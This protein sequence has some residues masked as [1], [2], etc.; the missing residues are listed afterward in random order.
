MCWGRTFGDGL[1]GG[2]DSPLPASSFPIFVGVLSLLA[3]ESLGVVQ[4]TLGLPCFVTLYGL[5]LSALDSVVVHAGS[6]CEWPDLPPFDMEGAP[7][8]S[9]TGSDSYLKAE[10]VA[11]QRLI[12]S[13]TCPRGGYEEFGMAKP[14][15]LLRS[16]SFPRVAQVMEYSFLPLPNGIAGVA[17]DG[18]AISGAPASK[19]LWEQSQCGLVIKQA[20]AEYAL[21]PGGRWSDGPCEV[22]KSWA[23]DFGIFGALNSSHEPMLGFMMDGVPLF[24]PLSN[25]S[26]FSLDSCGG[27]TDDLPFYHYHAADSFDSYSGKLLGCLRAAASGGNGFAVPPPRISWP[28]MSPQHFFEL[29]N[30]M[31]RASLNYGLEEVL[32]TN[33]K[34]AARFLPQSLD[35]SSEAVYSI[36]RPA[37]VLNYSVCWGRGLTLDEH[38]VYLGSLIY[39]GPFQKDYLCIL[40]QECIL[41]IEGAGLSIQSS[42][43]I[44][45]DTCELPIFLSLNGLGQMPA[46]PVLGAGNFSLYNLGAIQMAVVGPSFTKICWSDFP[47]NIV[48]VGTLEFLGPARL[49]QNFTCSPGQTCNLRV[50]EYALSTSPSLLRA[51]TSC[52]QTIMEGRRISAVTLQVTRKE[53]SWTMDYSFGI[54]PADADPGHFMLCWY[55]ISPE[56]LAEGFPGSPISSGIPVGML[57]LRG[58]TELQV[59]PPAVAGMFFRLQLFGVVLL[60]TD[61]IR[62][63]DNSSACGSDSASNNSQYVSFGS[64]LA[65][66]VR[67]V[68]ID[69]E[70]PNSSTDT[71]DGLR[72]SEHDSSTESSTSSPNLVDP[73]DAAPE[74]STDFSDG[75]IEGSEDSDGGV[76]VRGRVAM[77]VGVW[78]NVTIQVGGV[79]K[80]CWCPGH[81]ACKEDAD[82]AVNAGSIVVR[83]ALPLSQTEMAAGTPFLLQIDGLMLSTFDRMHIVPSGVGLQ[84]FKA[85]ERPYQHEAGVQLQLTV[86]EDGT[87]A[88]ANAT[89]MT[90]GLY[91]A[92]FCP[93]TVDRLDPCKDFSHIGDLIVL[94]TA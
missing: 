79:F 90:A 39:I 82:F 89:I 91:E 3:P 72:E 23:L 46:Q 22:V 85:H 8:C 5:G 16:Y 50:E 14:K 24:A 2:A 31:A 26:N 53:F 27:H 21:T 10:L 80:V 68:L 76:Q 57:T 48:E 62:I 71:S 35:N 70:E 12:V 37:E 4:C 18:L 83:G 75:L 19:T 93:G 42:L 58:P 87:E 6:S 44:S 88:W 66:E 25:L 9:I 77:S 84:C 49:D 64:S 28:P 40:T 7:D 74:N 92:C 1:N 78:E 17:L 69:H 36:Q 33:A 45:N 20:M 13:T 73:D 52:A 47:G 51:G 56:R 15:A 65:R 59:H 11:N 29:D 60:D 94:P 86:S 41:Q 55:P 67:D 81:H 61:E 38:Q 54:I 43:F 63:L 32:L 34:T 30:L